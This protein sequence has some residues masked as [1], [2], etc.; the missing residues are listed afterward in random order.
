MESSQTRPIKAE[1]S[2]TTSSK[3]TYNWASRMRSQPV[4]MESNGSVIDTRGKLTR[5]TSWKVLADA[6]HLSQQ[7]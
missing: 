7:M 1:S 4:P 2:R 3:S 5:G 6:V